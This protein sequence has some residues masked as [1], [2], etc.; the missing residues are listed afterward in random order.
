MPL[1]MIA[2]PKCR[3]IVVPRNHTTKFVANA[4]HETAVDSD[5][6]RIVTN[7]I[8]TTGPAINAVMIASRK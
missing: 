4:A 8:E 2:R 1:Y 3:K 5:E 7:M 6:A